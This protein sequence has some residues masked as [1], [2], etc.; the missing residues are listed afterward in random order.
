MPT[1]NNTL[2]YIE[3]MDL[4]KLFERVIFYLFGIKYFKSFFM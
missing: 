2:P 1:I 3:T 4:M